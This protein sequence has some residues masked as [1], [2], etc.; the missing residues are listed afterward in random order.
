MCYKLQ[1][2]TRAL[3][4]TLSVMCMK[5]N[6][7]NFSW[8]SRRFLHLWRHRKCGRSSKLIHIYQYLNWPHNDK[9]SYLIKNV[10]L[11][12]NC[13]S[14]RHTLCTS[15]R[16]LDHFYILHVLW[17]WSLFDVCYD[18]S[19]D[20]NHWCWILKMICIFREKKTYS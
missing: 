16:H 8:L 19:Y 18:L 17:H 3:K 2:A 4:N 13:L 12:P 9:S 15:Y 14:L 6:D 20:L 10:S 5:W 1:C 11:N 7:E